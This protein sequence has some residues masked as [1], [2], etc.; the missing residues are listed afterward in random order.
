[1]SV[2]VLLMAYGTPDSAADIEPYFTHIRGG[3]TPSPDAVSRLR[4][5][6]EL[7]GG[8]TPLLDVT[9]RLR[10]EVERDLNARATGKTYR[11]HVGMK[12]W[13]PFIGDVVPRMVSNEVS[14]IVGIALAPH[15]S[16]LSVGAYHAALQQ[17]LSQTGAGVPLRFVESWHTHPQFLELITARVVTTLESWPAEKR[18]SV[19]TLFSAH[20]LPERIR[21]WD[22]PY[23]RQLL[24]SCHAVAARAG[25]DNWRF[26]W[27]SAGETGEPWLG[28][29]VVSTIE[30]LY[31]DGV[32][33]VLS[34]PIGFVSEHLEIWYDIDYEARL[35]AEKLG[36]AFRRAPM[37][38]AEPAFARTIA[39]IASE[40]A[41]SS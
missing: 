6:Y 20:S 12:H 23:E 40:C 7:V 32:R 28:P 22:D 34:V 38:N 21:E 4:R 19:V 41:S 36:M 27:Q 3:R 24:E 15:Y 18:Q 11:V 25:I 33:D 31:R 17:A 1:M 2:G 26:A 10:D 8:R 9:N 5:R 13:H 14:E 39:S 16:R 37:L 30:A 29:D 35:A